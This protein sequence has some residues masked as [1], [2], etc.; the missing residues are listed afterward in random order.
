MSKGIKQIFA[1]K[2]DDVDTS[3]VEGVG[4]IRYE[5]NSIYKYVKIAH[6]GDTVAGAAGDPVAYEAVNGYDN[7]HVVIDLT[8]ADNPAFCAGVL[9]GTVAGTD[10]TSY[11]GWIK[12]Q[13]PITLLTAVT[14]GAAGAMCTMV[15]TDKTWQK[16]AESDGT[17]V[18][19]QVCGISINT[20]TGVVVTCPL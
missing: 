18:Y 17:A 13:G 1:T 9:M 2:L 16:A 11:Y 12:V 5:G 19:K 10:G 15:A 6:D 20:T 14:S 7:H 8:D 4:T 3:D